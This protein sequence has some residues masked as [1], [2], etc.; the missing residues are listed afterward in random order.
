MTQ[1]RC[2]SLSH[3]ISLRSGLH[4]I[5]YYE[6]TDAARH[7]ALRQAQ[8]LPELCRSPIR[9]AVGHYRE[10]L[11]DAEPCGASPVVSSIMEGALPLY[12]YTP[13]FNAQS[14]SAPTSLLPVF[15]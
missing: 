10:A 1:G 9:L 11:I 2:A 4:S 14:G 7:S 15:R 12:W 8:D 13:S 5:S 3:R 6:A